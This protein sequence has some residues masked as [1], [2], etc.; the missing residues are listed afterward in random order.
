MLQF[1]I[2]NWETNLQIKNN[3]E[4]IADALNCDISALIDHEPNS[5]FEK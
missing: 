4:K 2:M 1:V 5:I 3:Q